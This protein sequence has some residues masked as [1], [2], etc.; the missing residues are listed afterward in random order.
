M[1]KYLALQVI[2]CQDDQVVERAGVCRKQHAYAPY[3]SSAEDILIPALQTTPSRDSVS[4]GI[5]RNLIWKTD[6]GISRDSRQQSVQLALFFHKGSPPLIQTECGGGVTMN[7]RVRFMK[8]TVT[9]FNI[10]SNSLRPFSPGHQE[11]SGSWWFWTWWPR[12]LS[13]CKLRMNKQVRCWGVLVMLCS[14][15][16]I[17]LS[18]HSFISW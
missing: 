9:G 18:V 4:N 6:A 7:Q 11:S 13:R 16:E 8:L 17:N 1:K 5:Q 2:G 12:L 14:E 3:V 10:I 15:V